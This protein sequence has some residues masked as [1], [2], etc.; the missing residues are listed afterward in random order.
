MPKLRILHVYKDYPPV[1][2]GIEGNVYRLATA[3]AKLG[4]EVEVL[5]TAERSLAGTRLEDGVRVIR[6]PRWLTLA[7]TRLSA[8]LSRSG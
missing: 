7:S 8:P 5:V 3:Q 2:G 1:I 6:T 4:H